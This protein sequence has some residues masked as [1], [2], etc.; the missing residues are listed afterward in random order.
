MSYNSYDEQKISEL[1][2]IF[3]VKPEYMSSV[4]KAF[5]DWHENT[6]EPTLEHAFWNGFSEGCEK[7]METRQ[8]TYPAGKKVIAVDW[9]GVIYTTQDTR[10]GIQPPV[11]PPNPGALEWLGYIVRDGRFTV[12]ICSE[13]NQRPDGIYKMKQWLIEHGFSRQELAA[14][15]WPIQQSPAWLTLSAR[16]KLFEGRFPSLDE[17]DNFKPWNQQRR[18]T[19]G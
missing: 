14:V 17:I 15:H 19:D 8:E 7:A 4:V 10:S 3:N 9:E 18:H 6:L 1:A 11:N 16:V 13:L 2:R 12:T 5:T